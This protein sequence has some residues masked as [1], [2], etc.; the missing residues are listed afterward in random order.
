VNIKQ[1]D[2]E[3]KCIPVTVNGCPASCKK[4]DSN[5]YKSGEMTYIE[6]LVRES[7]VKL[8][9]SNNASLNLQNIKSC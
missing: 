8:L 4:E 7:L 3:P 6:N 5:L 9:N 1:C 2:T